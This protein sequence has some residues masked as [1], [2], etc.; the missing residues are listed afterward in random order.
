M[1]VSDLTDADIDA[2]YATISPN[3]GID[4]LKEHR[5]AALLQQEQN[6]KLS[7]DLVFGEIFITSP[8]GRMARIKRPG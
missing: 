2:V 7:I 3:H 4:I 6:G 8:G 5:R 1:P